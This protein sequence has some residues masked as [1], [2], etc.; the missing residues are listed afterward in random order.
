MGWWLASITPVGNGASGFT[1]TARIRSL[2]G[3]DAPV[4]GGGGGS[5]PPVSTEIK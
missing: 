3:T 4:R 2:I 1:F 5:S